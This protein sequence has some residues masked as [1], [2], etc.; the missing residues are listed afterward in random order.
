MNRTTNVLFCDALSN[1]RKR[2]AAHESPF[3]LAMSSTPGLATTAMR[4][5]SAQWTVLSAICLKNALTPPMH[6]YK[7][8]RTDS[9]RRTQVRTSTETDLV[10]ANAKRERDALRLCS[11]LTRPT[12]ARARHGHVIPTWIPHRPHPGALSLKLLEEWL[13]L[14][15]C[16]GADESAFSPEMRVGTRNIYS[17]VFP[18]S[19]PSFE[20]DVASKWSRA[21]DRGELGQA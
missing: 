14:E 9:H 19:L 1:G 8:A 15:E 13:G 7:H 20:H 18:R 17:S 2:S 5:H 10:L 12:S 11:S 3:I 16:V 6:C 4:G 21:G